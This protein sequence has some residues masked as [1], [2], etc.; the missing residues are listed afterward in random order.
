MGAYQRLGFPA[1][2]LIVLLALAG[3][4]ISDRLSSRFAAAPRD[5]AMEVV[6]CELGEVPPEAKIVRTIALA[7]TRG[8]PLTIR[9]IQRDCQCTV[10]TVS[11]KR[12]LPGQTVQT[13]VEYTTPAAS[14][15]IQHA[16]QIDYEETERPTVVLLSG[17]VGT[18]VEARPA[19]LDFGDVCAGEVAER[20]VVFRL[21]EPL[22]ASW[23]SAEL[24]L[25]HGYAELAG[26]DDG[27]RVVR[28]RVRFQPPASA[29]CKT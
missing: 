10:E 19:Q 26:A 7:N 21:K 16:I 15:P 18:W 4:A 25:E 23:A 17:T 20:E 5:V 2:V 12:I 9:S 22:P 14:G 6:E 27:G 29:A 3:Y 11:D 24:E 8:P 1:L 13:Q 28:Y